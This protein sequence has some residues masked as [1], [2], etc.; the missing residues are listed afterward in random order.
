MGKKHKTL[1]VRVRNEAQR[2]GLFLFVHKDRWE[3]L[4][5]ATGKSLLT[6]WP[7]N[8]GF[9]TTSGERGASR[10]PFGALHAAIRCDRE[11]TGKRGLR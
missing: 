1:I 3:F 2:A 7:S 8:G 10:S 11:H 6:W 9:T 4:S 5:N